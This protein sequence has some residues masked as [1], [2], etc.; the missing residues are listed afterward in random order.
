MKV[1]RFYSD[2]KIWSSSLLTH[3]LEIRVITLPRELK[4]DPARPTSVLAR[5]VLSGH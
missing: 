4:R 1:R 5:I 2:S 3:P